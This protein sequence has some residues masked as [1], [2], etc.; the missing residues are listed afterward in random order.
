MPVG[1][2]WLSRS[3]RHREATAPPKVPLGIVRSWAFL[4]NPVTASEKVKV[5]SEVSPAYLRAVSV[6]TMPTVGAA[7]VSSTW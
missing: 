7:P 6:T 3:H 4:A 5:T 1:G 2:R